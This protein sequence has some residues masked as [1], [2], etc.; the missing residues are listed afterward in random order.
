[1]NQEK[2]RAWGSG[3]LPPGPRTRSPP[4]ALGTLCRPTTS[5]SIMSTDVSPESPCT[6]SVEPD[7][8]ITSHSLLVTLHPLGVLAVPAWTLD[9][10]SPP[11]PSRSGS[12]APALCFQFCSCRRWGAAGPARHPNHP[13]GPGSCLGSGTQPSSS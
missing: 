13:G 5:H 3:G 12:G 1:M 11:A 8:E 7:F 6:R 10:P 9:S 2:S 4:M